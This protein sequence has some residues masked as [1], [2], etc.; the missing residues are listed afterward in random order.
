VDVVILAAPVPSPLLSDQ[1]A[2]GA[3]QELKTTPPASVTH[4]PAANPSASGKTG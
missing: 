4:E 2:T 1:V 3:G